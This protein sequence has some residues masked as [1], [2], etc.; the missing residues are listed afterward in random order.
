MLLSGESGVQHIGLSSLVMMEPIFY[1]SRALSESERCSCKKGRW[2]GRGVT[3]MAPL[4][5]AAN[6]S[7]D[8]SVWVPMVSRRAK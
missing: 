5:P 1:G 8:M 7:L 4:F 2:R 3:A 6:L